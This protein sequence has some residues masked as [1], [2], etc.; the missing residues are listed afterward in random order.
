MIAIAEQYRALVLQ[1][2]PT[3]IHR[4]PMSGVVRA[5]WRIDDAHPDLA[6]DDPRRASTVATWFVLAPDAHMIFPM[7]VVFGVN[8]KPIPGVPEPVK[9]IAEATHELSIWAMAPDKPMALDALHLCHPVNIVEVFEA[10]SDEAAALRIEVAVLAMV[11]GRL[12]PDS[13]W[14]GTWRQLFSY[15]D[16]PLYFA[17]T[18]GRMQ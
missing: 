10:A 13:D 11:K 8:F 5:A 16:F 14:R 1:S 3:L 6:P 7:Y 2:A 12:S 15:A 4:D 17:R 18:E 9:T